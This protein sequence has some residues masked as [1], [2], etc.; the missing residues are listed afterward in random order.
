MLI[1]KRGNIKITNPLRFICDRCGCEFVQEKNL[2]DYDCSKG[3]QSCMCP[4]CNFKCYRIN[5]KEKGTGN[6]D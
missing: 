3:K 2:C 6:A 4:C 5:D 1:V